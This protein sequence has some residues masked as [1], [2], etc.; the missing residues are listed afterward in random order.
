MN[1]TL[2]KK[3]R[4][5]L[6]KCNPIS[7][8]KKIDNISNGGDIHEPPTVTSHGMLADGRRTN[9]EAWPKGQVPVSKQ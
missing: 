8:G 9:E 4:E 5:I 3:E 2:L 1:Q 6:K 7:P